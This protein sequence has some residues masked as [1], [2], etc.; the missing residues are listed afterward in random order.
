M[1]RQQ[2]SPAFCSLNRIQPQMAMVSL[3]NFK[4]KSSLFYYK[5]CSQETAKNNGQTIRLTSGAIVNAKT[6]KV[7]SQFPS[8]LHHGLR[9]SLA[10]SFSVCNKI[11]D[12]LPTAPFVKSSL[13]TQGITPK[14]VT[15]GGIHLCY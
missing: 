10:S 1:L 7:L 14:L 3:K 11:A 12:K 2:T 8:F 9:P 13:C 6:L 5:Q 4:I 15:S